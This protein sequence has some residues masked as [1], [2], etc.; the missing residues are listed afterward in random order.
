ML[1]TNRNLLFKA[2]ILALCVIS[3]VHVFLFPLY[4]IQTER[5]PAKTYTDFEQSLCMSNIKK[6]RIWRMGRCP[7][8]GIVTI[9]QGG[10]LGNQMWEYASVW[11]LARRTG[12]E[13]YIPRCIKIKLDLVFE[14]LSVPTFEEIGHCPVQINHFVKSLETWNFT[15][16]SIILPRYSIQPDLVLTWVQ[17]I[18]QEFTI[19]RKLLDK[20]QQILH[21]AIKT[22]NKL[23][24]IFVGVHVRRTDYIGY[25]KRKHNI[26]PADYNFFISAM[27]TFEKKYSNC[28][29][30]MVSDDP[31][32][33]W[34]NFGFKSNVYVSGR[35]QKNSPALDM[36]ILASCNHTIYDYGTFG[37]WGAILAGGETIYYNLSH[38][39]SARIG[40]LMKNWHT[41]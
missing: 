20:S 16:Q 17:D 13:P 24:H 37:E 39:S 1:N 15:N 21:R 40:Q 33:C 27:K 10:R 25:L 38:H 8:Y 34:K 2:I 22:S 30:V 9:M 36:A 5:G 11:A 32:W 29:F 3:F 6:K 23:N 7:Q 4:D 12:L 28:I 35:R 19:K 26:H 41:I 18:V 31:L 14:Q